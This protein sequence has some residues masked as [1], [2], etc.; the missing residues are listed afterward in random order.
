MS[1]VGLTEPTG[2][3]ISDVETNPNQGGTRYLGDGG[4]V[5]PFTVRM[6]S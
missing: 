1:E 4:T 2:R 5:V 3:G 6:G